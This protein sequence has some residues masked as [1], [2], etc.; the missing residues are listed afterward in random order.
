M[1]F[2]LDCAR[3]VLF[4]LE[5]KLTIS[6]DLEISWLFFEDIKSNLIKYDPG[7][8]ANTLFVLEEAGFIIA[9]AIFGGDCITQ[10]FVSRI[11]YDGY[12]FIESIRPEPV[13]HK[14]K[15][16]SSKIGS[17]SVDV[18]SQIAV[19]TLTSLISAQLNP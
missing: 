13:W 14:V 17:F 6:S 15:N 8:I 1:K 9:K 12:Q 4:L 16:I 5:D 7:E 2:N 10:F 11:T 3:D 19:G 18:I